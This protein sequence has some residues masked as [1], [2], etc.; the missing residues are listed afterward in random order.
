LGARPAARGAIIPILG[1]RRREQIE[2]TLG[3]VDIELSEAELKRLDDVSC[4]ELGFSHDFVGRALA[5]GETFD[6]VDH[7]RGDVYTE[8]GARPVTARSRGSREQALAGERL[9]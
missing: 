9:P 4:I 7:H 5:Y 2:D 1:A 8:L 3:A 6:P